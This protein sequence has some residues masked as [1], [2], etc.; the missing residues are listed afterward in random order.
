MFVQNELPLSIATGTRLTPRNNSEDFPHSLVLQEFG[1]VTCLLP[2]PNQFSVS[3][4]LYKVPN[5]S[6][7]NVSLC[8]IIN[9]PSVNFSLC[10]VFD[11][12]L[13]EH[14]SL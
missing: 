14:D 11:P 8:K 4:S 6:F 2:V 3:I 9:Q 12:V 13:G 10:K 1:R 5:Q 7:V